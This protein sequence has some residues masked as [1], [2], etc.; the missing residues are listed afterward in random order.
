M[1][2]LYNKILFSRVMQLKTEVER[3]EMVIGWY[4][5][6]PGY[7]CWLSG[8]DVSTQKLHQNY[9]EPFVAVVVDPIRT[10]AQNKINFGAF[11]TYPDGYKPSISDD[12]DEYQSIPLNKIEDFGV[13]CKSYYN[14][15]TTIFKSHTDNMLLTTL[16]N[17]YWA[18]TLSSSTLKT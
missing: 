12:Q 14:L 17:K 1:R 13:H 5:S 10:L 9:E 16:W 8:I 6:H 18:S 7:G 3:H 2:F 4:H 15:E 11:R